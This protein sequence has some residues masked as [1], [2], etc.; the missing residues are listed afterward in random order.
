LNREQLDYYLSQTKVIPLKEEATVS[1]T[2]SGS[3]TA[4]VNVI[5]GEIWFIKTITVTKGADVTVSSLKVDSNDT[6]ATATIA[7]TIAKYGALITATKD[8]TISGSNAGLA[9][10]NLTVLVEGY[11]IKQ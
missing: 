4:T 10:Q 6:Y 7:D 2:A 1:I 3:N 8:I 5:G 9:A 11:K